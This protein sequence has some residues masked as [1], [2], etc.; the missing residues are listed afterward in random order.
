MYIYRYVYIYIYIYINVHIYILVYIF[1]VYW[2]WHINGYCTYLKVQT[3]HS[4]EINI[5]GR[6]L[7]HGTRYHTKLQ[8]IN[9]FM[10]MHIKIQYIIL[11]HTYLIIH[12]DRHHEA[13][14]HG[15][16][17]VQSI[18]TFIYMQITILYTHQITPPWSTSQCVLTWHH[19]RLQSIRTWMYMHITMLHITILHTPG[20]P[21]W[22]TS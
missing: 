13:Y 15:T 8:S 1:S 7:C 12:H 20:T 3:R 6:V 2:H 11:L 19:S 18:I 21:P 4:P 22:S 10:Y 14:W 16:T 5:T 9:T 17:L